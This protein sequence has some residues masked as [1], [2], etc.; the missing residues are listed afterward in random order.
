MQSVST[1]L[2]RNVTK[3]ARRG[4]AVVKRGFRTWEELFWRWGRLEPVDRLRGLG[5]G[6][7]CLMGD[8]KGDGDVCGLRRQAAGFESWLPHAP[9]V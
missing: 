1:T 2:S 7:D 4:C 5:T 8:S 3:N 9:A 6:S